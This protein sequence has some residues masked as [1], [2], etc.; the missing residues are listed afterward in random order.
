VRLCR[1]SR[2]A[3]T[4]ETQD[5]RLHGAGSLEE[6]AINQQQ[7]DWHVLDLSRSM[8]AD[9]RIVDPIALS[10]IHLDDAK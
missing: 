9:A 7:V 5:S 3:S 6:D 2:Q 4:R 1:N 10:Y 8:A